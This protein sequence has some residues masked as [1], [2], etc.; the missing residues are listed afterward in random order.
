[1]TKLV[2][3]AEAFADWH[4]K[5]DPTHVCFFSRATF[6]WWANQT[7]CEIDFIGRDVVLLRKPEHSPAAR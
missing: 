1:M 4:Y 6:G 2:T 5:L 3:D 7:G